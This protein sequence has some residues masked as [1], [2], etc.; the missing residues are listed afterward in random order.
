MEYIIA[1]LLF[2][3]I[4]IGLVNLFSSQKGGNFSRQFNS[5]E[6]D[7]RNQLEKN[8]KDTL[9]FVGRQM[10]TLRKTVNEQ[11]LYLFSGADCPADGK[12]KTDHRKQND[13][14]AAVK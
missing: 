12:Y 14:D 11:A 5:F 13:T 1:G 6:R 10:D 2:V 4:I 7:I 9:D 8:Q 3:N